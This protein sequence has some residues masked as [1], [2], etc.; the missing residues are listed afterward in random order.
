[1]ISGQASSRETFRG[2]TSSSSKSKIL[3]PSS[4]STHLDCQQQKQLD[5]ISSS[6]FTMASNSPLTPSGAQDRIQHPRPRTLS[7][8]SLSRSFSFTSFSPTNAQP[9]QSQ[10][11]S[12][13]PTPLLLESRTPNHT[14]CCEQDNSPH[15]SSSL[16]RNLPYNDYKSNK[17]VAC[18]WFIVLL[19]VL[20]LSCLPYKVRKAYGHPIKLILFSMQFFYQ[21]ITV[22]MLFFHGYLLSKGT[23]ALANRVMFFDHW[24]F[25][26]QTIGFYLLLAIV[27]VVSSIDFIKQGFYRKCFQ[28]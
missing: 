2:R 15:Q 17:Y 12:T 27:L 19:S 18:A 4:P 28:F 24:I 25:K 1:M 5:S 23:Q 7:R 13:S 6:L 16:M 8:T 22:T 11:P 21:Y 14:R 9:F 20:T 3:L 10:T 26:L